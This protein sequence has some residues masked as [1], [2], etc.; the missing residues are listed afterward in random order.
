MGPRRVP[1]KRPPGQQPKAGKKR[2][3]PR[4]RRPRADDE[5]DAHSPRLIKIDP[6]AVKLYRTEA[7]TRLDNVANARLRTRFRQFRV[8][9][10]ALSTGVLT[11]FDHTRALSQLCEWVTKEQPFSSSRN[12]LEEALVKAVVKAHAHETELVRREQYEKRRREHDANERKRVHEEAEAKI[13]KVEATF[14]RERRELHA[15][16]RRERARV[17]DAESKMRE[18]QESMRQAASTT[19]KAKQILA[20]RSKAHAQDQ[21]S[22]KKQLDQTK[23]RLVGVRERAAALGDDATRLREELKSSQRKQRALANRNKAAPDERIL[24]ET[25]VRA[26][27]DRAEYHEHRALAERRARLILNQ[28]VDAALGDAE[29]AL[30]MAG[31]PGEMDVALQNLSRDIMRAFGAS[32]SASRDIETGLEERWAAVVDGAAAMGPTSKDEVPRELANAKATVPGV[33]RALD[34]LDACDEASDPGAR[35]ARRIALAQ[36]RVAADGGNSGDLGSAA[37][38]CGLPPVAGKDLGVLLG[39]IRDAPEEPEGP[40]PPPPPRRA[41]PRCRRRSWCA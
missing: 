32:P 23:K 12:Q 25:E 6:E 22:T 21:K 40:P 11:A 1:R 26:A 31:D 5:P 10:L 33:L 7:L 15:Q 28:K 24:L 9:A 16:L 39:A 13:A 38:V 30:K 29:A 37:A 19:A 8:R 14:D 3:A 17:D 18:L 35:H 41:G 4:D 20:K 27:E 34:Q 2:L 36:F